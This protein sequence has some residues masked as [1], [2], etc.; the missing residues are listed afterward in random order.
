MT[1]LR[2]QYRKIVVDV[3]PV[4]CA[5][6]VLLVAKQA[7]AVLMC[8]LHDH[9]RAGQFKLAYDRLIG[10]GANVVGAA[11]NGAPVRQYSYSYRGYGAS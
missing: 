6:E 5:S 3:P 1:K 4:L 2:S 8:A 9:S 10:A 11:L 7:D